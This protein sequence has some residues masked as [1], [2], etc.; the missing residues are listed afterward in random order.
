[1]KGFNENQSALSPLLKKH[2][3]SS[4]LNYDDTDIEE[5]FRN[6]GCE[7]L[8]IGR[9]VVTTGTRRRVYKTVRYI[10][11]C[12]HEEQIRFQKFL[13]GQGVVC[14]KCA[15]PRGEAHFAYNPNLTDEERLANRDLYENIVWRNKVFERD[16]YT[17]Q[18]CHDNRGGNLEAHHLNSYTDFPEERFV[19]DNGVTLCR[20]CHKM[21]HHE[22]TY[23]HNTKEQ[24]EIWIGHDNT[25]VSVGTKAPATP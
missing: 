1:M 4:V 11:S 2:R 16:A 24:F 10:A 19:V 8:E 15:R 23:H 7:L 18:I 12:G 22:Y 9:E 21:F 5:M 13:T 14:H 17:C 3:R 25:E 6:K 20:D